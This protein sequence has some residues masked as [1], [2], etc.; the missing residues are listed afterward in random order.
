MPFSQHYKLDAAIVATWANILRRVPRS[1]L[2]MLDWG[3]HAVP[4]V[5]TRLRVF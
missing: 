1:V 5:R 3:G 2:W 4:Q